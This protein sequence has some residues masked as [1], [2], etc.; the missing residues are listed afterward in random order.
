MQGLR[1][2]GLGLGVLGFGG[3]KVAHGGLV[4]AWAPLKLYIS[5]C[6]S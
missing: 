5:W 2:R 4:D 1:V 3:F 6:C